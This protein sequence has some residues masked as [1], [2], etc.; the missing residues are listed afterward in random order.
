VCD[1]FVIALSPVSS[2]G[3]AS[4]PN[5]AYLAR[6]ASWLRAGATLPAHRPD[7]VG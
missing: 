5:T 7:A 6:G 3:D 1:W 2:G 4:V